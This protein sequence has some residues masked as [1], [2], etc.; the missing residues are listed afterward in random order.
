MLTSLVHTIKSLKSR[1]G[2]TAIVKVPVQ[3]SENIETGV[4]KSYYEEHSVYIVPIPRSIDLSSYGNVYFD[5]DIQPIIVDYEDIA[6]ITL[7]C[8]IVFRGKTY[9]ITRIDDLGAAYLLGIKH[10]D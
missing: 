5:V 6:T 4:V 10:V 3:L 9:I 7:D 8:Q 2:I 1:Y